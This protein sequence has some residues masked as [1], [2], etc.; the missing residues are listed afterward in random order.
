MSVAT[1]SQKLAVE[2]ESIVNF[3]QDTSSHIINCLL[4]FSETYGRRNYF[5]NYIILYVRSGIAS[6]K[7]DQMFLKEAAHVLKSSNQTF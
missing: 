1:L 6:I 4:D 2:E 3:Y 7:Y 5:D